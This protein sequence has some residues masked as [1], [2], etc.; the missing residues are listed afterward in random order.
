MSDSNQCPQCG[1]P[2]PEAAPGGLC[3][4]CMLKVG[5][6]ADSVPEPGLGPSGTIVMPPSDTLPL[7]LPEVGHSAAAASSVD[8]AMAAW[9]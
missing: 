3:P 1:K 5:A 2:I 9:V 7:V 8:W 4:E 6:A